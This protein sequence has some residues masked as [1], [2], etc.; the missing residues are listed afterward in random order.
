MKALDVFR[1][2]IYLTR[3]NANIVSIKFS[4]AVLAE[5][6]EPSESELGVVDV[7]VV[8]VDVDIALKFYI[9]KWIRKVLILYLPDKIQHCKYLPFENMLGNLHCRDNPSGILLTI[10]LPI[11]RKV[12]NLLVINRRI[13]ILLRKL[14]GLGKWC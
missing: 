9:L 7:V 11:F 13:R 10:L 4:K 8:V 3:I 6:P 1:W 14:L 12:P 5:P 2:I